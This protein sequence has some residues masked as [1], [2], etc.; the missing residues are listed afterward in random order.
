MRMPNMMVTTF[1]LILVIGIVGFYMRDQ[2]GGI[3]RDEIGLEVGAPLQHQLQ[4]GHK[5]TPLPIILR[6]INNTDAVVTLTADSPCK[7]FRYVVTTPDGNFIQAVRTPEICTETMRQSAIN[8]QDVIEEIRQVPLD[9]TRYQA[10]DY[11]V[12][13]KFWNYQGQASFTLIE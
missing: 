3:G 6:L 13:V 10:G 4:H 1:G 7:I 9:T 11:S 5:I 12:R 8:G 2:Q